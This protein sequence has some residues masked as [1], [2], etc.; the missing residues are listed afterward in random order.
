MPIVPVGIGG[1]ERAMPKGAKLL[2]P[3]KVVLIVGEPMAPPATTEGGRVSRRAVRELT[4]QLRTIVQKL[5]DEAQTPRRRL[6]PRGQRCFGDA[7]TSRTRGSKCSSGS[8]S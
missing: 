7:K 5:F 2:R 1:S 4:E 3:V 6:T 8:V